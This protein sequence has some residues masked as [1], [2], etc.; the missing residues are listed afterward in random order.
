MANGGESKVVS[1][2]LAKNLGPLAR[3]M[4]SRRAWAQ[5]AKEDHHFVLKSYC[6][7]IPL[8]GRSGEFE[9]LFTLSNPGEHW[10][11]AVA[12]PLVWEKSPKPALVALPEPIATLESQVLDYTITE[13]ITGNWRLSPRA[14]APEQFAAI[15]VHRVDAPSGFVP[16]AAALMLASKYPGLATIP[17]VFATGLGNVQQNGLIAAENP[18]VKR[19]GAEAL[20]QDHEY[21]ISSLRF[22]AVRGA[23]E[24]PANVEPLSAR[25]LIGQALLPLMR[26][27]AAEPTDDA[28]DDAFDEYYRLL[29]GRPEQHEFYANRLLPQLR[30]RLPDDIG[31]IDTLITVG[32]GSM[33]PPATVAA[34]IGAC[35]VI[36]IHTNSSD[37][38]KAAE[39]RQDYVLRALQHIAPDV[40]SPNVTLFPVGE[41]NY[42]SIYE[43][44]K[45]CLCRVT[46]EQGS[47]SIAIDIT[48]GSK[49]FSIAM[50]RIAAER[51]PDARPTLVYLEQVGFPS[52]PQPM[53]TRVV[54]MPPR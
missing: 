41:H 4:L 30:K 53:K 42:G 3:R 43:G 11:P 44:I 28:S 19:A 20:L 17:A 36:L 54:V 1:L 7:P 25:E 39:I 8:P 47:T 2:D 22:F 26:A 13:K 52:N 14:W 6:P 51:S 24:L 5:V 21:D 10:R 12:I 34:M 38:R 29:G 27:M 48:G 46:S 37:D 33:Q 45:Q 49:L 9:V 40:T 31:S 18:Q 23:N 35:R 50:D 32:S 16:A 15:N